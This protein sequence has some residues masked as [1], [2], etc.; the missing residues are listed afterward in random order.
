MKHLISRSLLLGF[1]FFSFINLIFGQNSAKISGS[2]INGNTKEIVDFASVVLLEQKDMSYV[3]GTQ[4]NT[5]GNFEFN[6]L[7]AGA[8]YLKITFVGYKDFEQKNLI[9]KTGQN[10]NLGNVTL[11]P[12]D[13]KILSEVMIEG[14][15]SS[16]KL[17]IDRKVFDVGQSVVSAGGSATDLLSDIPSLSVDMDGTVSLRGTSGVQILID[18]KPSAMA[19]GDIT[20]VLQSMPANTIQSVEIITNP[21]SKYEADGQSG[22]INIILKKN[23]RTGFNGIANLSAGSYNNYNSGLNMNYRDSRVNYFGSYSYNRGNYVGDGYTLNENLI[24]NSITKNNSESSRKRDS[25]SVKVGLDYYLNDKNTLG[26]SGGINK[27]DNNNNESIAYIYQNQP[28]LNGTSIRNSDRAQDNF[29]FDLNLDYKKEFS[30]KGEELVGNVSFGKNNEEGIENFNQEFSNENQGVDKRL[31]DRSQDGE[32]ANIQLDYTLP[33][34]EDSRFEAG[35]K[36][37]IRNTNEQQL[38]DS[39]DPV[40]NIF[41]RDYDLTNAFKLEDVVHAFYSNYQNKITS[42]L[43]FQVGLRLEQAYLN[44]QYNSLDPDVAEKER[45]TDGKLDYLR[46]YPS[47]FLTQQLKNDQQVQVSYTRRVRRPRGWQVNPFKDVSDPMNIRMGNANLLPEDIHSFEMSYAKFWPAVSL[48]S[49]VYHRRVNDGIENI[50]TSADAQTSAVISQWLNMGKREAT[51]FEL[52]SK[53]TF[54][55]NIDATG[56]FNFYYNKYFGNEEFGLAAR[57]GYNWDANLSTNIKITNA[58]TAQVKGN[59]NAPRLQAQGQTNA[60]FVMDAG[61]KM[62]VLN[63]KGSIL[64]NVRDLFNQRVWSGYTETPQFTQQFEHRWMK[65]SF[66][67]SFNYR[68]GVQNTT[69]KM[70]RKNQMESD[71]M[72]GMEM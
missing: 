15:G 59:Y 17:G 26:I 18:G 37:T 10:L 21:S 9:L 30:R 70:K 51:G 13:S 67:L 28:I 27:R 57:D 63:N 3:S 58:L 24:N 53:V 61:L 11:L 7:Q 35:Y 45:L 33:F 66:M 5:D 40:K 25:H 20:Q 8:Y 42:S 23:I 4:S 72:G 39:F 52:I 32:N 47:M 48:T 56:N 31:N 2:I 34:S 14:Q 68:F 69:S 44:T 22:I 6:A 62:E 16:M 49:S 36:S 46:L 54:N 50:R 12:D 60:S 71:D 64:F 19:G 41:V 43:G 65:R 38:S 55:R 1:L 29:G